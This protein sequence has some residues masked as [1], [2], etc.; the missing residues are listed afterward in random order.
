MLDDLVSIAFV[1]VDV[2]IKK[3]K[4][5]K[6]KSFYV[7]WRTI[8]NNSMKAFVKSQLTNESQ[9][10]TISLDTENENGSSL[11]ETITSEDIDEQIFL[12]NSLMAIIN[13]EKNSFSKRE[14]KVISLFLDG[15]EI[16]EISKMTKMNIAKVYRAYHS[17][18]NK[19][20]HSLITKK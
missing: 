20:R 15:Y 2:A 1:S 10:K 4:Y 18:I 17:A 16:K 5:G 13:N 6:N 14:K 11:H 8:A 12:H 3:F 9:G 19:I 7:Y